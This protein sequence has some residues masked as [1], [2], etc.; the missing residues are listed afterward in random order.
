MWF[1]ESPKAPSSEDLFEV[2]ELTGPKH[3]WHVPRRCFFA[4]FPLMSDNS[5]TERSLLARQEILGLCF[6]RLTC[7][8][9]YS[10]LN[11]EIFAQLVRKQLSQ[12]PKIFSGN[13]VAFLKSTSIFEH[14][15]KK[16]ELHSFKNIFWDFYW[17]FGVYINFWT[18][19]KKRWASS[20]K[21]F[22][23]YCHRRL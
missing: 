15:E 3:Y 22:W 2:K 19:W 12:K 23:S 18:I 6:N 9:M 8:H 1:L 17:I 13:F 14:F 21:C 20:L 10:R 11:R 4:N 16:D 7:D 5:S